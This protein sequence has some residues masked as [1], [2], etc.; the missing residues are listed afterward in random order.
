[1]AR[2]SDTD[3]ILNPDGSVF[4]LSLL[5]DQIADDIIAVG[6]PD[7]V[8]QVSKYFDS[9]EFKSHKRE[10]VTHTGRVGARRVT[11]ISTGIG[12]DNVEIFFQELDA[13]ANIDLKTREPRA[14][15]RS[16]N[17][18]RVGTSGAMRAEIPL[19]THLISDHAVGLD[20]LLG[21]YQLPQ[22]ESQ[23]A[24]CGALQMLA[25]LPVLPYMVQGSSTM[26]KKIG[27]GMMVGNTVTSPGFY[28]PQGRQVRLPI[29]NPN[30]L[31]QLS[32]FR[33]GPFL[34]SNFEMETSAYFAFAGMMGHHAASVNAIIANRA[35][36]D[37][38]KDP[39]VVIDALI[40]RV[41]ERI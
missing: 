24:I 17:I 30:L 27:E 13:L 22:D 23:K 12:S 32:A 6:D 36:R 1:M 37:F 26:N 15:Q 25:G 29:R 20:N 31:D 21:F 16:L 33:M 40:R 35:T 34:L 2:I 18:V 41:V 28:A 39:K 8:A 14:T 38:S 9:I 4:H 11:V 7:R 5:P 10:F 19:G 3:L